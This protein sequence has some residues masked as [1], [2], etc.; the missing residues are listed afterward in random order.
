M[1][2]QVYQQ[3]REFEALLDQYQTNQ[4]ANTKGMK[5]K[6]KTNVHRSRLFTG[7]NDLHRNLAN[8]GTPVVRAEAPSANSPAVA[9]IPNSGAGANDLRQRPAA[10]QQQQRRRL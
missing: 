10:Q 7:L 2:T 3:R 8:P 5:A 9:S 1:C 4:P 6:P